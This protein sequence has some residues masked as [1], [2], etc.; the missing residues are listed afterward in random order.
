MNHEILGFR[1]QNQGLKIPVAAHLWIRHLIGGNRVSEAMSTGNLTIEITKLNA[2]IGAESAAF[3]RQNGMV[4]TRAQN[5]ILVPEE[6][7]EMM[8]SI[9]GQM[10]AVNWA[11]ETQK[12]GLTPAMR[13]D[14]KCGGH[15]NADYG[16]SDRIPTCSRCDT[17]RATGTQSIREKV[18]KTYEPSLSDHPDGFT[19][20]I[21]DEPKK[22]A[23]KKTQ[24]R[25]GGRWE[26]VGLFCGA[27]VR[28]RGYGE[29][30][31]AFTDSTGRYCG[32]G[33]M[34]ALGVSP[35]GI[36]GIVAIHPAQ[37]AQFVG[38]VQMTA[39]PFD[40]LTTVDTPTA[41]IRTYWG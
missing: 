29:Q 23:L 24:S 2:K 16:L 18:S 14:C 41:R 17:P 3:L 13:P 21:R 20:V 36:T 12:N 28:L 27:A 31:W 10:Q 11:R 4:I 25:R 5:A 8:L 1:R 37:T 9:E 34:W 26:T 19:L 40:L 33:L 39:D 32:E 22:R 15:L 30:L 35:S 7:A 38:R 6:A